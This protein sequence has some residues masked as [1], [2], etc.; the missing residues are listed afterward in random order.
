MQVPKQY[1][2]L[3]EITLLV[4]GIFAF[5]ALLAFETPIAGA[6]TDTP[7]TVAGL[8]LKDVF[9]TPG[10]P[11]GAPL[12]VSPSASTAAKTSQG[13]LGTTSN[14]TSNP[15]TSGTAS[16]GSGLGAIGGVAKDIFFTHSYGFLDILTASVAWGAVVGIGSYAALSL[17][18]KQDEDWAKPLPFALGLG[19]AGGVAAGTALFGLWGG[20]GAIPPA[21]IKTVF[22]ASPISGTEAAIFGVGAGLAVA[23]LIYVAMYNSEEVRIVSFSCYPWEAPSGGAKCEECNKQGIL[24]CSEYQCRALGQSCQLLNSGSEG[25]ELCTWVNRNDVSPPVIQ[26]RDSS[27]STDLTYTP[28]N[29]ISPPDRGVFI[30]YQKANEPRACIPAFKPF[31]FGITLN[32]PGKC[33]LDYVKKDT[34]DDMEFFLGGEAQY[35]YNH[36]QTLSLPG[37]SAATNNSLV[38]RNNGSFELFVRCMDANGNTNPANFVFKYCVGASKDTTPPIIIG[39]N[40]LNDAPIAFNQT[41]ADIELYLNEPATCKWSQSIQEYDRMENE[42]RCSTDATEMNA[43]MLYTCA[44]KLTGLKDRTINKYYFLCKDQPFE[45]PADRNENG[46]AYELR[47]VGTKPLIISKVGPNETVRDAS[48]VIKVTLTAETNEG[49]NDGES[50]CYFGRNGTSVTQLIKFLNTGTNSHSQDLFLTAGRYNYTIRCVDLGGN[51]DTKQSVFSVEAD[52]GAPQVVRVYHEDTFLK[53]VTS[54]TAE[55]VY[56]TKD[57]TYQFKDGSA[58]TVKEKI[59]HFAPWDSKNTYYIKCKDRFENE[60]LPNACSIIVRPYALSSI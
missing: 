48:E 13:L 45:E 11:S 24:P 54:E 28:D 42:L 17:F 33:K 10:S 9:E 43:Q 35:K 47:L 57:C 2:A 55:C 4:M 30:K 46:E 37:P 36:T 52:G 34:F 44:T 15:V 5:S 50:V 7:S 31:T 60:P 23:A 22:G 16:S 1:S 39:T 40:I 27:L 14:P 51:V 18:G 59:F 21:L 20:E 25:K 38:V 3:F 49:Y 19:T 32:E 6:Q 26:P 29:T 53:L 56:D 58:M 8:T 12:P 41:T